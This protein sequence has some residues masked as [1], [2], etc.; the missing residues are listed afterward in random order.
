MYYLFIGFAASQSWM[1]DGGMMYNL[2]PKRQLGL[3]G[4]SVGGSVGGEVGVGTGIGRG[5]DGSTGGGA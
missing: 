2:R 5:A 4:E 1:V 3:G